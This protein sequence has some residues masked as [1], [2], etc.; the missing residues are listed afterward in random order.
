MEREYG[1]DLKN[2]ETLVVVSLLTKLE[3][4]GK[5]PADW[6]PPHPAVQCEYIQSWKTIKEKWQ[7]TLDAREQ[8]MVTWM[9]QKC[10]Q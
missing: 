6:M 8:A 1:N 7:M 2:P 3:R 9:L 4:A 10:E 5:D